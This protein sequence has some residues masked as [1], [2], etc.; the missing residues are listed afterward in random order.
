MSGFGLRLS[1]S[2]RFFGVQFSAGLASEFGL[3]AGLTKINQD[4]K[5]ITSDIFQI[6]YN[7]VWLILD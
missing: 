5:T 4:I 3:K 6:N 7:K 1:Q 2:L